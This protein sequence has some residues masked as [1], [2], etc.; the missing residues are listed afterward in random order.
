MFPFLSSFFFPLPSLRPRSELSKGSKLK[1]H[2]DE[3]GQAFLLPALP[4]S[5]DDRETE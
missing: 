2:R 5:L 3:G 4:G 1:F